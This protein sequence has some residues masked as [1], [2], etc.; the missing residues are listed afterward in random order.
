[1]TEHSAP[2][3]ATALNVGCLSISIGNDMAV[4]SA[5]YDAKKVN[6]R[7]F[8]ALSAVSRNEWLKVFSYS[9]P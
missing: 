3:D 4:H 5:P 8:D 6:S 9:A 2:Y 1:M 7:A